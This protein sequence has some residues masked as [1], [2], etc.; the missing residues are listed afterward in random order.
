MKGQPAKVLAPVVVR[1]MLRAATRGRYPARNRV[2]VLLSVKAGLRACEISSLQWHM[3]LDAQGNIGNFI[4]LPGIA[5]K[6]GSGRI[7]PVHP[8]LK[9]ALQALYARSD[10]SIG[11]VALSERRKPMGSKAVVNWFLALFKHLGC[12]GCSSHSGR[13]TFITQAARM[14]YK[15]GGSLRDVQLL[16]G[17]QSLNTTQ[18]YI[19]GSSEAQR[20]LVRAL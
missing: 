4:E 10:I 8:E 11:P 18:A 15:T 7:I 6:M 19:A 1:K 17:H 16:A 12:D 14:I 2:M 20:K 5:A 13:R 9:K 3:L